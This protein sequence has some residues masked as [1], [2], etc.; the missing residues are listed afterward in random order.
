MSNKIVTI[1]ADKARNLKFTY[2]ALITLQEDFGLEV[3]KI[4]DGM[5]FKDIRSFYYC[6]LKHEDKELTEEKVGDLLDDMIEKFGM[7]YVGTKL[8]EAVMKAFG[9][10]EAD[11]AK[12]Q[13]QVAKGKK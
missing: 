13:K 1:E 11:V 8:A 6:G 4:G 12:T 3:D 5:T 9:I 10:K 7:E 2:N